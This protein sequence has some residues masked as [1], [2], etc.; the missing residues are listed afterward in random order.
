[1][2]R[3]TFA[4]SLGAAAVAAGALPAPAFAKGGWQCNDTYTWKNV[5]VNCGGFVPGIIFNE[6]E[7]NLIYAR[8]DVAGAFRW[9]EETR[10]W[11]P[12][13]DWVPRDKWG[14]QYVVS[15]ATDPVETDRVY[16]A[17]GA[18]TISWDANNGSILYSDDKGRLG[19]SP[20]CRSSR[21]ATC[22]AGAWANAWPSIPPTTPNCI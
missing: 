7:P 6:T 9:Q 10:T 2:R 21:V 5:R 18:Y 15:M 13:T 16:A 11:K 19:A 1:M 8:T 22:P 17:V 20:S 3:R 4:A 14:Y 12:L